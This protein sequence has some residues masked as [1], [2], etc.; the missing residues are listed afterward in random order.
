MTDQRRRYTYRTEADD[1]A[2]Q[3]YWYPTALG[4]INLDDRI[5]PILVEPCT[6]ACYVERIEM[7]SHS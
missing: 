1:T 3:V 5:F 6:R 2:K 7:T 4:S